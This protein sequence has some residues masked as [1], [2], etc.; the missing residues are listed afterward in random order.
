MKISREWLQ[1]FFN[2][3][4]P[5]S[6]ALAEALTFHAFEI[7]SIEND[8]LDVKVT[9]NRGHDALSHRGIAKEIAAILNLPIKAD[10][11]RQPVSLEP[12]TDALKIEIVEPALCRRYTACLI[13][14]VNVGPSPDWLRVALESIG[15][16]S[17]NN[18]VD[19]TNFV[20]FDLGQPLHAFDAG[21]ITFSEQHRIRV[22][23]A[24]GGETMLALD[25]KEYAFAD[26]MLLITDAANDSAIGIAGVKGG[27]PAGITESTKDIIIESAN[28]DPIS[29]RKTAA[30]LKLRTDASARFE[31]GISQELAAYGMHAAAGV[32]LQLAGGEVIGYADEYPVAPEKKTVAAT[33]PKINQILGTT[34]TSNDI[35]DA[36]TRLDL[37][38]SQTGESY[39]VH[40]PFERLDITI[41]E[42]LAEE[43]GRIAGYDKVPAVELAPLPQPPAMNPSFY[44]T[45][46]VREWLLNEGFSEIFTSVFSDEGERAV[47]NKVDSVKP[48]LRPTLFAGLREALDKNVRNKELL[49]LSQVRLFEIGTV[50]R[51]GEEKIMLGLAVESV[52]KAK[53]ASE[54]LQALAESLGESAASAPGE[55]I[56]IGID[57]LTAKIAVSETYDALPASTAERYKPF[58]RYPFIVRDIALWVPA[59]TAEDDVRGIIVSHAGELLVR[60]DLF[61]RFEKEGRIS[62]AFRL[63]FQ[64]PDRTLFDGDANERMESVANA[65][66]EKGFEIR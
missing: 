13:R 36:F 14:N 54:Y 1:R 31:Q 52:K 45:E 30:A 6:A 32:I 24:K 29:V 34:L 15:Q 47:L 20:L 62:Y 64:S 33:V 41:A 22:R 63:V 23:K 66:K 40:P 27:K 8:I 2:D 28:F 43:A 3:P 5:E 53:S 10:P 51:A 11:L 35:A 44:R 17:I 48:Y 61:D 38:H 18:V 42:D 26:S 16:R 55:V 49:G 21:Q 37:A 60:I 58:S 59:S 4:L 46:R 56:E 7:E 25:D 50:W 57:E 12:K 65:L 9:P 19:A 39:E